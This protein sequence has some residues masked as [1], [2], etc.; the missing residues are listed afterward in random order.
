MKGHGLDP[1][2]RKI[3]HA[4][5]QLSLCAT[6]EA[7]VPTSRAPQQES[8]PNSLQLEKACTQQQRPH[9]FRNNKIKIAFYK[10]K[11]CKKL[12]SS[13]YSRSDIQ[14]RQA[15]FILFALFP[16][17]LGEIEFQTLHSYQ[18]NHTRKTINQDLT[19]PICN[20]NTENTPDYKS[21]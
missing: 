15:E 12:L 16:Q 19:V 13:R 1:W 17:V 3:P 4:S 21:R 10:K 2:S 20:Q 8:S 7:G 9:V 14:I 18:G 5:G 6:T 11:K